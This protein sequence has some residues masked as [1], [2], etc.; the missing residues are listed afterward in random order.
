MA[1]SVEISILGMKQLRL[2]ESRSTV[3]GALVKNIDTSVITE[4]RKIILN[5]EN[6]KVLSEIYL[7]NN[8]LVIVDK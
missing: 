8:A 2:E 1:K 6:N 4:E 5:D 7:P 3:K